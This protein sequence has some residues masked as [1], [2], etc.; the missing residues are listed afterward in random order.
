MLKKIGFFIIVL[1]LVLLISYEVEAETTL[2]PLM[3]AEA[4]ARPYGMGG[5]FT[6]VSDDPSALVFNPAGLYQSGRV[7]FLASGGLVADDVFQYG[8]L[9]ETIDNFSEDADSP[10]DFLDSLPDEVNLTGQGLL[11]FKLGSAGAGGNFQA[12]VKGEKNDSGASYDY[13][14]LQDG[15]LGLS[16]DI[17][18]IPAEVGIASYGVNIRYQRLTRGEYELEINGNDPSQSQWQATDSGLALD[19]G[20]MLQMTPMVKLGV[21]IENLWAADLELAADER[22][23]SYNNG[24][25]LD[26]RIPRQEKYS[27]ARSSRIGVSARVPVIGT[28][29]AADIDNFPI[30]TEDKAGDPVLYLGFENDMLFRLVTVRGGTYSEPDGERVF[31]A[32]FGLNFAGGSADLG[33]G[34]APGGN[35]SSIQAAVSL[36]L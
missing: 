20:L 14:L 18:T 2:E 7:G 5:A 4:L 31:T 35:R 29:L 33:A 11:G 12:R 32:G 28:T 16:G 23:Y 30:L 22:V 13:Q 34:F 1:S 6:A 25:E 26:E 9:A 27:P 17:F 19:G 8:E 21:M 10:E 24:W 36:D 3:S 15:R